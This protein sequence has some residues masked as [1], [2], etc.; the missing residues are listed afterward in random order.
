MIA[1]IYRFLLT[2]IALLLTL[3]VFLINK[4]FVLNPYLPVRLE[5]LPNGASYVL[6]LALCLIF[7]W[8]S[9]LVAKRLSND[10]MQQGSII[11]LEQVNDAFLPSYLGYFFVALSTTNTQVFLI[12]FSILLVLV[13]SSRAAYF[14]PIFFIFGFI[15]RRIN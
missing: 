12:V 7:T 5:N 15:I 4:G 14:N 2:L 10:V 1:T 9:L 11:E 6:Y 8:A 13:F 3:A